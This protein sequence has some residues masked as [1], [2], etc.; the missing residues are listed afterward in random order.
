MFAVIIILDKYLIHVILFY[1]PTSLNI[2]HKLWMTWNAVLLNFSLHENYRINQFY[3][4]NRQNSQE[5]NNAETKLKIREND[6]K[7]KP[8]RDIIAYCIMPPKGK[9]W[10][11]KYSF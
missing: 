9:N 8:L 4:E 6:L 7:L 3:F 1:F 10:D 5:E 11:Y 2:H